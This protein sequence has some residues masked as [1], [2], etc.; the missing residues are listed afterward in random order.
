MA[1]K[2]YIRRT[3]VAATAFAAS[4]AGPSIASRASE[5]L[6]VIT[7]TA[8]I[9]DAAK[10]V[11]GKLAKVTPLMGAN[12]DPHSYRPTR[13]DIAALSKA[14]LILWNGLELEERLEEIM[15]NISK[16][17]TVVAVAEALPEDKLLKNAEEAH[18]DE[19]K[20]EHGHK[21]KKHSHKKEKHAHKK[22]KHAHKHGHDHGHKKEKKEKH[23][24]K[25]E[26]G[27]KDE[28][29]H[30]HGEYDP[31]VWMN[32]RVWS[33]VVEVIRDAMIKAKPEHEEAFTKN[34]EAYIK[35]LA[36]LDS[37][38][39][40]VLGSVTAKSRV[41]VTAHDAFGYFGSAYDY[42]VEGIQGLSTLNEV[43][44]KRI[45]DMAKMLTDNKISAIF[46]ET[47][48]AGNNVKAVIEGAKALGH[49]VALGR[50]IFSGSMGKPGTYEGTYIGMIDHNVT[51]ISRALGGTAPEKGMNGKLSG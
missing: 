36:K 23:A 43:G 31:H 26:H 4:I 45:A 25:E 42:K 19:H 28:H 1:F 40:K 38:A 7:S 29:A 51:T 35:E 20:D 41:L 14:N 11:G 37:Y 10:Q 18:E 34:A 17:R 30:A 21:E 24:H 8:I 50:E 9:A 47:T 2:R 22:E 33:H 13:S 32:P 15:E 44:L 12:I 39:K 6:N 46:V 16:R 5:P 48:V 3:L 27:H 49:K